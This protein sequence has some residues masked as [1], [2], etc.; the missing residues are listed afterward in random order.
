MYFINIT[1]QYLLYYLGNN[2]LL[3]M[4]LSQNM[5]Y[6]KY[7]LWFKITITTIYMQDDG[8][9]DHDNYDDH[10]YDDKLDDYHN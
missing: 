1:V 8:D 4:C 3:V 10:N 6:I 7:W 5:Q 9:H 2:K